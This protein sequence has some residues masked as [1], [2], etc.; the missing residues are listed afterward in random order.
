MEPG[1]ETRLRTLLGRATL[2][3]SKEYDVASMSVLAG[4]GN[5]GAQVLRVNLRKLAASETKSVIMKT[6][7]TNKIAFSPAQRENS[8]ERFLMYLFGYTDARMFKIETLFYSEWKPLIEKAIGVQLFPEIYL[9]EFYKDESTLSATRMILYG[10]RQ[11]ASG[12]IVME[13]L[14]GGIFFKA[15]STSVDPKA[16]ELMVR[17]AASFSGS[18]VAFLKTRNVHSSFQYQLSSMNAGIVETI[19][20]ASFKKGTSKLVA[21]LW[22]DSKFSCLRTDK[23]LMEAME[24]LEDCYRRLRSKSKQF[25]IRVSIML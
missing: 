4:G 2:V 3:A 5:T 15:T 25:P 23:T 22:G 12:A 14:S 7:E 17:A 18:S 1:E 6:V 16:L 10:R 8:G 11:H 21:K 19:K 24:C 20:I 9:S 13:D